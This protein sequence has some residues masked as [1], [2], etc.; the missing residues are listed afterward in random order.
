M[1]LQ[2]VD[3]SDALEE[4][5]PLVHRAAGAQTLEGCLIDFFGGVKNIALDTP[6]AHAERFALLDSDDVDRSVLTG[7]LAEY[8]AVEREQVCRQTF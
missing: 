5:R 3:G 1:L 4:G 2:F 8:G 7:S 6:H